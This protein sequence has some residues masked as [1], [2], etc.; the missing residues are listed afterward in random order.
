MLDI[1]LKAGY[2]TVYSVCQPSG[3]L[4]VWQRAAHSLNRYRLNDRACTTVGQDLWTKALPWSGRNAFNA[5]GNLEWRVGGE[6]AGL[7]KT[8]HN[9]THASILEAGHMV[10]MDQPV[11]MLHL[12][13]AFLKGE[14]MSTL[15]EQSRDASGGV[16]LEVR[17]QTTD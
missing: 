5:A 15:V 11:N 13:R 4:R 12:L 17:R 8:A 6:V 16:K 14:D 9:F 1:R 2:N 3:C 10:P 7:L